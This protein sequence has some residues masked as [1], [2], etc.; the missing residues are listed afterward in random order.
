[1]EKRDTKSFSKINWL[2]IAVVGLVEFIILD[3]MYSL[4]GNSDLVQHISFAGTIVSIILAVLAIIYTYYQNFAQ[5]R[6]SDNISTQ[7][8]LLKNVVNDVKLS[9]EDFREEFSKINSIDGIKDKIDAFPN[10]LEEL[11]SVV[12]ADTTNRTSKTS[13]AN[14]SIMTDQGEIEFYKYLKRN[15]L[16]SGFILFLNKSESVKI[17]F[18]EYIEDF[19]KEHYPE[20]N[21][22]KSRAF[23][24][25]GKLTELI[26]ILKAMGLAHIEENEKIEFNS[27]LID[28][29]K[30]P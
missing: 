19:N 1:M 14:D 11:V 27:K 30:A 7:I 23:M 24:D 13:D 22:I 18:K 5:T 26:I 16:E 20:E 10:I 6:D 3:K 21:F 28:F 29:L 15:N 8:E 9:K 4:G 12:Y 17:G 25:L 2:L